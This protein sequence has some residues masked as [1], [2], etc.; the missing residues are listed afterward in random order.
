MSIIH[1]LR[2]LSLGPPSTHLFVGTVRIIQPL[3]S[4]VK[5][6]LLSKR[7][8][9]SN[10]AQRS[11]PLV[12]ASQQPLPDRGVLVGR[13]GAFC[14]EEGLHDY[15]TTLQRIRLVK[16]EHGHKAHILHSSQ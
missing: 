8:N 7:D 4:D 14:D 10:S 11:R 16:T 3:T 12:A 9:Y 6:G 1:H 13:N 2:C 15:S 5:A